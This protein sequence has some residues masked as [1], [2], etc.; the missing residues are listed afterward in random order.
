[1]S[2]M[3]CSFVS[4]WS[5]IPSTIVSY[6]SKFFRYRWILLIL[7][8]YV[9]VARSYRCC[10]TSFTEHT[11]GGIF[12]SLHTS[13]V[14]LLL[15]SIVS[16]LYQ[17]M[18]SSVD[19]LL[20]YFYLF[21]DRNSQYRPGWPWTRRDLPASAFQAWGLKLCA[22]IPVYFFFATVNNASCAYALVDVF[23]SLSKG[24]LTICL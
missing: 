16:C 2:L 20:K 9:N 19:T 15:G 4:L 3:E 24:I 11:W 1:M 21:W 6:P 23:I 8:F 22:I 13:G 14:I 12:M 10:L 7:E 18:Y 17:F 5:C